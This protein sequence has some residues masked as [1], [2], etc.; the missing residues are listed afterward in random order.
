MLDQFSERFESWKEIATYLRCS[1]RTLQRWE[2]LEGL[3]VH[4]HRHGKLG[5]VY[6]FRHEIDEGR[7]RRTATTVATQPASSAPD[8]HQPGITKARARWRAMVAL[9]V[10]LAV[11]L[12]GLCRE[13]EGHQR[14]DVVQITPLSGYGALRDVRVVALSGDRV[15]VSDAGVFVNELSASGIPTGVWRTLSDEQLQRTVPNGYVMVVSTRTR[16]WGLPPE[17]TIARQK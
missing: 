2:R 11:M 6:A 1:V 13:V 16:H 8:H 15:S 5:S 17:G 12:V 9:P 7:R 3:P 10:I 14:G 4:R